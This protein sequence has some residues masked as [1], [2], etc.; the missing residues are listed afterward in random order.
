[1]SEA[2]S[3]ILACAVLFT[4]LVATLSVALGGF[5]WQVSRRWLDRLTI[6]LASVSVAAS[7]LLATTQSSELQFTLPLVIVNISFY[8]DALSIYF[9]SWSTSS[10]SLRPGTSRR[11]LIV[12]T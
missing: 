1:M 11:F 10:R 9:C 4:P 12:R 8:L 2:A 6:V 3:R 5:V 7:L